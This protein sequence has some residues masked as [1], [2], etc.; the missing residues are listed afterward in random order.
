MI[1]RWC[2][3]RLPPQALRPLT[4]ISHRGFVARVLAHMLDSLVRVS[5][6]VGDRH[7]VRHPLSLWPSGAAFPRP[8]LLDSAFAGGGLNIRHERALHA[9]SHPNP[10]SLWTFAWPGKLFDIPGSA[11]R[12]GL[13]I[14]ASCG[15]VTIRGG[16]TL[17]AAPA[18]ARA[19]AVAASFRGFPNSLSQSGRK[20]HAPLGI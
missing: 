8:P 9:R 17:A 2:G 11:L 6:R 19:A 16:V 5:R 13:P 14:G 18:L 4:F 12:C 15:V 10:Y 7:F 1:G 3:L 20:Y